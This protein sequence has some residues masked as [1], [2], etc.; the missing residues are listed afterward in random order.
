MALL[1]E[2][3]I[4]EMIFIAILMQFLVDIFPSIALF[5]D[6]DIPRVVRLIPTSIWGGGFRACGVSVTWGRHPNAD[7]WG[8]YCPRD[9]TLMAGNSGRIGY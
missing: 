4:P 6:I 5:S 1:Q 7:N 8:K 3:T 9:D 2:K